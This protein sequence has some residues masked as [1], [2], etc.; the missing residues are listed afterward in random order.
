MDETRR[1]LYLAREPL[2]DYSTSELRPQNLDGNR[3]TS[4]HV[5]AQINGGHT[6]ATDFSDDGIAATDIVESRWLSGIL[7]AFQVQSGVPP[8]ACRRAT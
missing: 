1:E 8:T 2:D 6:T 7:Y 4:A 5:G 3:A